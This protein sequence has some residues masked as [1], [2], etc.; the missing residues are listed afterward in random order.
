MRLFIA[1]HSADISI[2]LKKLRVN[3]NKRKNFERKWIPE[4]QWH[5]PI[6]ALGRMSQSKLMIIDEVL[7]S[8]ESSK[9]RLV[10]P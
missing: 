7:K 8:V 1:L 3:L 5:I 6:C 10:D 4:H 9:A 2:D